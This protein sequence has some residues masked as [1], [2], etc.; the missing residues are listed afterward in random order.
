[1]TVMFQAAYKRCWNSVLLRVSLCAFLWSAGSLFL[2]TMMQAHSC[3]SKHILK[4]V[5]KLAEF[6]PPWGQFFKTSQT[7]FW[8][9]KLCSKHDF[10]FIMRLSTH[11]THSPTNTWPSGQRAEFEPPWGQIF[12]T[13]Q[14]LL[15]GY[16]S[17]A[18]DSNQ[19]LVPDFQTIIKLKNWSEAW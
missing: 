11:Y 5:S 9:S 17:P 15:W 10:V 7:L 18:S 16:D 8:G 6:E 19:R 13:S 4:G 14:T 1:M 2:R 3:P 12:K